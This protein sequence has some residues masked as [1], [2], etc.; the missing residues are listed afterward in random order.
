MTVKVDIELDRNFT[1]PADAAT[2]FALLADVPKSG[3]H[4][5]KVD[6][7]SD[8]GEGTFKWEM[9]KIGLGGSSIQTVYAC[10]YIPDESAG[11][12]VWEPVKGVGN[13]V[14]EGSWTI[15][16]ADGGTNI[17]F[18]TNAK[19]TLPLPGL[20]KIAISPVV[21]HEFAAMVDEYMENLQGALSA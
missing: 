21:K 6:T 16:A 5:P 19:L 14:V 8:T 20:L 13:S 4:F 11:T 12:I 7:L 15:T 10:K 17:A 9:E 3:A 1:V 2:V 18:T